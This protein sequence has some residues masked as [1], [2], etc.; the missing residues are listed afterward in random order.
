MS[1]RWTEKL[2]YTHSKKT[3]IDWAIIIG[4][5]KSLKFARVKQQIPN[6]L[7]GYLFK[8]PRRQNN[9]GIIHSISMTWL[10]QHY[11]VSLRKVDENT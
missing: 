6:T 2:L 5:K 10:S 8:F 11:M 9:I 1:Q 4:K 3:K 7:F